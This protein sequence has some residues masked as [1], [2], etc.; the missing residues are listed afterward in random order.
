[1]YLYA[2]GGAMI[3]QAIPVAFGFSEVKQPLYMGFIMIIPMIIGGGVEEIGWRGLLQPK[4]EEKYPHIIAA[5]IVGVIWAVWHLP[6]WFIEGTN[7]QDL[8]FMW[9]GINTIMLSFFIGSVTFV[10]KSIFMAII[11]HAS[12]N[13]FWEV[14]PATDRMIPSLIL[15]IYVIITSMFIDHLYKRKT[16]GIHRRRVEFAKGNRSV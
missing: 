2:I 3:I 5:I 8:N 7:Q 6:L 10:S 11:A 12:I 14:M 1:M 16:M 4:L 9:F 13:A 15:M